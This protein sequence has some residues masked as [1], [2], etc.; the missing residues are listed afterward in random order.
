MNKGFLFSDE[1]LDEELE[2]EL[3]EQECHFEDTEPCLTEQDFYPPS[4][5]RIWKSNIKN[6]NN[7]DNFTDYC[8]DGSSGYDCTSLWC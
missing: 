2:E 8:V 7:G 6:I 4:D 3:N 5:N 1:L